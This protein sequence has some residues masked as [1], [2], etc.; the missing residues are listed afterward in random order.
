MA[1][2]TAMAVAGAPTAAP[3]PVLLRAMPPASKAVNPTVSIAPATVD[4]ACPV[5]CP[6]PWATRG[7]L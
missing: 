2:A 4:T 5:I 7:L 1:P 3:T 6:N